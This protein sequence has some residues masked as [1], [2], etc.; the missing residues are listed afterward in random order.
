MNFK[1]AT[2]CNA[3]IVRVLEGR[4][5]LLVLEQLPLPT[6]GAGQVRVKASHVAQNPIDGK[7]L[8]CQTFHQRS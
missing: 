4:P 6:P 2:T 8:H 7:L 1:M 5:P 3:L